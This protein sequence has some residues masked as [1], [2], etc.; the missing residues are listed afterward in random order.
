MQKFA[1]DKNFSFP[2]LY[3]ETQEIAKKYNAECTPD[4]YLFDID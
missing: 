2:Y 1:L 4:F 3:D